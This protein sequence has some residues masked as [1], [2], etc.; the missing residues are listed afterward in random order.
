MAQPF[1]YGASSPA[2]RAF[3][4][5]PNDSA[6]LTDHI[7]AIVIG[8]DGTLAYTA[9]DGT[10]CTTNSLAAGVYPLLIKRVL[11]TGTTA[12]GLTGLV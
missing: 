1:A 4:I 8:G 12:T 5:T 6:D 9:W 11:A 2:P 7:R 10:A 3:A